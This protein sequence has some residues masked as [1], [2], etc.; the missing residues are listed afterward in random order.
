MVSDAGTF[1]R[2]PAARPWLMFVQCVINPT[3]PPQLNTVQCVVCSKIEI[4][5]SARSVWYRSS[6]TRPAPT[7]IGS[8]LELPFPCPI[9]LTVVRISQFSVSMM[10]R[11]VMESIFPSE[12]VVCLCLPLDWFVACWLALAGVAGQTEVDVSVKDLP[13]STFIYVCFHLSP[14]AYMLWIALSRL[15]G[16]VY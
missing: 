10:S 5:C 3:R 7:F 13:P 4:N 11:Q 8:A 6:Q 9:L 16:W 1:H 12:T 14:S 2:S 15:S